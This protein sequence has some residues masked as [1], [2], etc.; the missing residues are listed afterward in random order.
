MSLAPT[1]DVAAPPA[2]SA[3]SAS[4][5]DFDFASFDAAPAGPPTATDAF[6]FGDADPSLTG[7]PVADP[8]IA[9]LEH[10]LAAIASA[11]A[12]LRAL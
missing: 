3:S 4:P 1:F 2:A 5:F 11:R 10:F 8:G 6:G 9:R 7:T 12:E